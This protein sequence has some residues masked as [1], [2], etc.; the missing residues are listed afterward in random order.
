MSRG[1]SREI[2]LA[3]CSGS[4]PWKAEN[5]ERYNKFEV[6]S[7]P[8]IPQVQDQVTQKLDLTMLDIDRGTEAS[9]ILRHEIA[10][11]DTPH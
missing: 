3:G 2:A 4:S 7:P 5:V 9:Y 10:E 11:D 8:A 6:D 1:Q